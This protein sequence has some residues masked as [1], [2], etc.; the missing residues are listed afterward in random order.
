MTSE[1]PIARAD[2]VRNMGGVDVADQRLSSHDH[3]HKPMTFFWR[4]VFDQKLQQ[5][6]SNAY[7][8]F[9]MWAE[10]LLAQCKVML[11]ERAEGSDAAESDLTVEELEEFISGL[12]KMMRTDRKTWD[13]RLAC[14]LM[15]K[16]SVGHENKGARRTRKVVPVYDS[17]GARSVKVCRGGLCSK[18]S[19]PTAHCN[20]KR[21]RGVCLV[22]YLQQ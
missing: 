2:Y 9:L 20:S 10:V 21:A 15:V 14:L 6:I 22:R 3:V 11:A 19:D 16:C 17:K 7:L 1:Q 12:V 18:H 4:R 13:T 5:A 8:F